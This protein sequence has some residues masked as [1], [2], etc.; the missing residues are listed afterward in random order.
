[1][2]SLEKGL[3]SQVGIAPAEGAVYVEAYEKVPHKVDDI[4][5]AVKEKVAAA[6]P[7][8]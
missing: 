8:V 5:Q 4:V 2:L 6:S 1:M 7:M 3:V